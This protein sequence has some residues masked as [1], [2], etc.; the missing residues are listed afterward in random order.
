MV[1]VSC[2]DWPWIQVD[3]AEVDDPRQTLAP[4]AED[5]FELDRHGERELLEGALLGW[6]VGPPTQK[7]GAVPKPATPLRAAVVR[8][9]MLPV[10]EGDLAHQLGPQRR[11]IHIVGL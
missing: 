8:D 4:Q 5:L 11:P 3:A 9:V 2:A 1:H 6:F 10:V 7:R